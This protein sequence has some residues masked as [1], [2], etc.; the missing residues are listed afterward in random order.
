MGAAAWKDEGAGGAVGDER[1]CPT[2]PSSFREKCCG[3]YQSHLVDFV[4]STDE[5][6]TAKARVWEAELFWA[7]INWSRFL[8]Y[9][10]VG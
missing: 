1:S 8:Q 7:N 5:I 6:L 3:S 4:I 2:F 9:R 10:E